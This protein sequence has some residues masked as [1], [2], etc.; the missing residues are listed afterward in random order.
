MPAHDHG[1]GGPL[2]IGPCMIRRTLQWSSHLVKELLQGAQAQVH[3]L[4]HFLFLDE[5]LQGTRRE[6][7]NVLFLLQLVRCS[8]IL[9]LSIS[10]ACAFMASTM[11][12][13]SDAAPPST[14]P[15]LIGAHTQD[16]QQKTKTDRKLPEKEKANNCLST[17]WGFTRHVQVD[18][19]VRRL[20]S[21]NC[22]C[23]RLGRILMCWCSRRR[24]M[25]AHDGQSVPRCVGKGLARGTAGG[26]VRGGHCA[27][28]RSGEV[29]VLPLPLQF[30]PHRV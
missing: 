23:C 17:N 2:V 18:P 27:R 24:K 22:E 4:G 19:C 12:L 26:E 30:G 3:P 21:G 25:T 1:G 9:G 13:A 29:Q 20:V 5:F 7:R 15:I 16:T 28:V 11:L 6:F 8:S 14:S 10:W